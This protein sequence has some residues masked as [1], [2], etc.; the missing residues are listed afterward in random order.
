VKLKIS[1]IV[2]KLRQ[3]PVHNAP[4]GFLL[5]IGHYCIV[6]CAYVLH[7]FIETLECIIILSI[8]PLILLWWKSISSAMLS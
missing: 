5:Y 7:E 8:S 3:A 2:P 1:N 4:L 6:D